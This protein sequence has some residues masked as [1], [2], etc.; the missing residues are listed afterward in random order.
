MVALAFVW[1]VLEGHSIK[2]ILFL[3]K[4]ATMNFAFLHTFYDETI[5]LIN[6]Q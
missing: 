6:Q 2:I 1:I 4:S 5:S 3:L